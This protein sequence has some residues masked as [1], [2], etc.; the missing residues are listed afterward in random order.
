MNSVVLPDGGKPPDFPAGVTEFEEE[1]L[2]AA[3]EDFT[4]LY[5]A[6]G[7]DAA[8]LGGE[9]LVVGEEKHTLAIA[10]A[11]VAESEFKGMPCLAG[12]RSAMDE[13]LAILGKLVEQGEAGSELSLEELLGVID[14]GSLFFR[15][16]TL[17]KGFKH[18]SP[19]ERID[20]TADMVAED[21]KPGG[22]P[23]FQIV[24]GDEPASGNSL[25][26]LY[27]GRRI[28]PRHA[29]GFLDERR[30][31]FGPDAVDDALPLSVEL[32]D[33]VVAARTFPPSGFREMAGQ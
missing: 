12:S 15:D 5:L 32:R 1:F 2:P 8:Q 17:A 24:S 4:A 23:V 33:R 13:K 18:R 10:L 22:N 20:G 25:K 11:G 3:D 6:E 31:A 26:I 21:P 16:R 30:I 14:E 27:I 29:Q 9:C 7:D 28:D 19:L